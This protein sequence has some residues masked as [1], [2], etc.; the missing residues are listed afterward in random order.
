MG[1][2]QNIP[3]FL[4]SDA[5]VPSNKHYFWNSW[6]QCGH[7]TLV[8][9]NGSKPYGQR[10]GRQLSTTTAGLMRVLPMR[11]PQQNTFLLSKSQREK[12]QLKQLRLLREANDTYKPPDYTLFQVL[13]LSTSLFAYGNE[14]TLPTLQVQTYFSPGADSECKC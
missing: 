13:A 5:S 4:D 2:E 11:A 3:E 14:C 6:P 7:P 8:Y 12:I 1:N 10:V 9:H